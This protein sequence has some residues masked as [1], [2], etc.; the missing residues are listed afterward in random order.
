MIVL[1]NDSR[2]L[3]TA[4]RGFLVSTRDNKIHLSRLVDCRYQHPQAPDEI[5]LNDLEI[6]HVKTLTRG[7]AEAAP[8]EL[9]LH[10]EQTLQQLY[11]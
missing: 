7:T 11:L 2:R 10:V 5:I 9:L 6:D 4:H 1:Q 3:S 8:L